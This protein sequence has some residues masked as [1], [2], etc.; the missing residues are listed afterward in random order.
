MLAEHTKKLRKCQHKKGT[1]SKYFV[2][3]KFKQMIAHKRFKRAKLNFVAGRFEK[4]LLKKGFE[5]FERAIAN[6]RVKLNNC[7]LFIKKR[8][9]SIRKVIFSVLA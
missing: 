8:A 9:S 1:K 4:N 6:M 3:Q 7:Q 2:F 5:C